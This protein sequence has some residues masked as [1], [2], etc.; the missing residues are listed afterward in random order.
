MSK[1]D[2][3][4]QPDPF[5]LIDPDNQLR[6]QIS[7]VD[8]F[9][10]TGFDFCWLV[11]EPLSIANSNDEEFELVKRF[12][13]GQKAL[14][15]WWCLD[16]QV[17]NGG[18]VQFY[19]NGYATYV[20]AILKGLELVGDNDMLDLVNNAHQ[21]YLTYKHLI[22]DAQNEDSFGNDLYQ[23]L[24]IL[25]DFDARYYL[26]E[27]QTVQ[28]MEQYAK[29]HPNEF[30]VDETGAQ[31]PINF[32]GKLTSKFAN[33]NLE[34]EFHVLNGVIEGELKTYYE[35]GQIKSL[36]NFQNALQAGEQKEW[37]ENGNQKSIITVNS[38]KSKEYKHY[39]ENGQL[40][41]LVTFIGE[42]ER[43]GPWL[44]F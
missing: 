4:T 32:T 34:S 41:E 30:C 18:F 43:V 8:F 5:T 23:R 31:F 9:R 14:Y 13:R 17:K 20:P 21:V 15:F 37:Y 36:N 2:H 27:P 11:L 38:D 10:S 1:L 42:V 35:S 39:Y 29:L 22:D 40:H 24:K 25:E 26:L 16:A 33:G 28:T 12:S 7:R 19:Y 44:K 6:P 3:T